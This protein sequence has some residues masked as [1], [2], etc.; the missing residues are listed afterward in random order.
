VPLL[1]R[2][3]KLDDAARPDEPVTNGA[4]DAVAIRRLV[5]PQGTPRLGDLLV[6]HKLVTPAELAEAL[7]QQGSSGTPIGTL[8]VE[9]GILD[10][11]QLTYVLAEQLQLPVADLSH[12]TPTPEAIEALPET[13]ARDVVAIPLRLTDAGLTVAVGD[14][15]D[16]ERMA[17][18]TAA[19]K[20]PLTLMLAPP[21]DIRRAI[22]SNY[23]ALAGV[24][25]HIRHFEAAEQLRR[26]DAA[27]V[28]VMT[29]DAPVVQVA[30]LIITQGLRDRAS[31]IHIEPQDSVVRIRYRIDGALHDGLR[32]PAAMG[33][34][35][36]SRIKIMAGINIVEKRRSQDGQ[37][38]MNIDGRAL[39]IRVAT[40][41]TIWG[42]KAVL[43]LLDK[44]RSLYRLHDL[45]MPK[46]T[47]EVWSK[48]IRSPFGMVI[49][50]GPTGS[51][52]TTTLYASLSEINQSE[53]N[54][55]TIEDPVEYVFPSINQIQINEQAEVTFANGLKAILR[56][57]PDVI[58][59][60]EIRDVETARIAV[61]SALTG[62]LVLS[63][64]HATDA[65][66][67]LHRFLD[68]QIE[69]FLISS[70]VLAVVGQRLVRR[71]CTHCA[72]EHKPSPDEMVF[73]GDAGGNMKD[74]TFLQGTGCNFCAQTGY[75]DRLGVY[76]LLTVSP[77]I[78]KLIVNYAPHE[79]IRDV[80]IAQGMKP[81]REE[82][83]RL[84]EAG[85]TTISEVIRNI[86]TL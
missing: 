61:Q 83:I 3:G 19:A 41:A 82:A 13:V 37:I 73:F 17:S 64:L 62:H 14:P 46:Q 1:R 11:R 47:H 76:E 80:A 70:A 74:A 34:A 75:S 65:A 6:T 32:L 69:A 51:G 24:A 15:L 22:D 85:V 5:M 29:E 86:Y 53:R 59:V 55:M 31:D 52:K 79:E 30:N 78:K 57:D 40:T 12:E 38:A 8:L 16:T 72:A 18:L 4:G 27:A 35:L 43:R 77:A 68:M 67:A 10:E 20:R 58:L 60:G 39:D 45:G 48:L 25:G 42:E 66:S 71:V 28:D 54:I 23:R 9:I 36:V 81:M 49:C 7:L 50:T 63:S 84:V 21:G 56:Q 33:P 2:G 26:S 44:S